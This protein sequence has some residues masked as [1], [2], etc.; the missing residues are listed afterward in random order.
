V[1]LENQNLLNPLHLVIFTQQTV[2]KRHG[3]TSRTAT[4]GLECRVV[5]LPCIFSEESVFEISVPRNQT[6]Q[7]YIFIGA[8]V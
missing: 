5:N 6:H 3:R 8:F 7:R 4:T 1:S 2:R